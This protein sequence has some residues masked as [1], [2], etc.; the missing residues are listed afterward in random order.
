MNSVFDFPLLQV[1]IVFMLSG[2]L[3]MS[4]TKCLKSN[5]IANLLFEGTSLAAE[6]ANKSAAAFLSLGMDKILNA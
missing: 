2:K 6:V 1:W 5:S 4:E 3:L